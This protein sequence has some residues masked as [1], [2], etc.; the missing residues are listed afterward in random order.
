M[1]YCLRSNQR[2]NYLQKAD[3]IKVSYDDKASIFKLIERY[4]GKTIILEIPK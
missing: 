3:E 2:F 1:K 4:P